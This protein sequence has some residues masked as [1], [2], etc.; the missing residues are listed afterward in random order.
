MKSEQEQLRVALKKAHE[1]RTKLD[2]FIFH[3]NEVYRDNFERNSPLFG[4]DTE[5]DCLG[6]DEYGVMSTP[7][8]DLEEGNGGISIEFIF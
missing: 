6:P 7:I 4:R 8:V 1:I 2:E 3:L 5:Q